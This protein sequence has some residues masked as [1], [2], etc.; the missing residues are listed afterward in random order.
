MKQIRILCDRLQL[1]I[2]QLPGIPKH[3]F[4][5]AVKSRIQCFHCIQVLSIIP[6]RFTLFRHPSLSL[7]RIFR[8]AVNGD[9]SVGALDHTPSLVLSKDPGQMEQISSVRFNE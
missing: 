5:K 7:S 3:R 8:Q 1:F 4:R 2:A 6:D 9:L